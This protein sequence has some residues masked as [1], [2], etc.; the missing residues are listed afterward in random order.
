MQEKERQKL[1]EEEMKKEE[2][3]KKRQYNEVKKKKERYLIKLTSISLSK[4]KHFERYFSF[5]L[6]NLSNF[7]TPYFYHSL[8]P[9][10]LAIIP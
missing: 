7:S 3:D 8:I 5:V 2:E 9:K 10:I 4:I 1:L 6:N